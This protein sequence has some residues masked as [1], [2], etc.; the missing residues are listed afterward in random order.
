MLP[1]MFVEKFP[2]YDTAEVFVVRIDSTIEITEE[3]LKSLYY[4]FMVSWILWF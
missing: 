2:L 1:F 4:L 3:L